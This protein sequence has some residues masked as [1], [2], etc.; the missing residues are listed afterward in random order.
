MS[1]LLMVLQGLKR[2]MHL[3]WGANDEEQFTAERAHSHIRIDD[4]EWK[5][6]A[7]MHGSSAAWEGLLATGGMASRLW[8]NPL[9]CCRRSST[10]ST[11][12]CWLKMR[13]AGSRR[14]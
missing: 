10:N 1:A 11:L 6:Q 7:V 8:R 14:W 4:N 13:F 12:C 3:I 9:S 2:K 5:E